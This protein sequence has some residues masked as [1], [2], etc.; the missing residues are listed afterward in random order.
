[1]PSVSIYVDESGDLG[2]KHSS[3]K[4]FTIG[5]VFTKN[6]YPMAENTKIKRA[7]KNVNTRIKNKKRKL[8]EFKFSS[9]SKITRKKFLSKIKSMDVIIGVIC[10]SKDSVK[11]ELK[12][13]PGRLYRYVIGDT[14][15]TKLVIDYF[16]R[17]D[18]YNSIRFVIDR[19]LSDSGR[20]EFNKYCEEKTSFR[21]WEQ[22]KNIDFRITILHQ[23]SK[24]VPMLQVAD[25]VA[26]AVQRKFDRGD[27]SYYDIIQNKIK[28]TTKWDYNNKISW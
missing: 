27:S 12:K 8:S 5:Y 22:D 28:Y 24:A 4:F 2:F 13:D 19:S 7:L 18:P 16:T 3:S 15:I 20:K 23:D 26:G 25:Y 10:I 17:H 9:D 21:S 6:R 1:M 11:K 14:I